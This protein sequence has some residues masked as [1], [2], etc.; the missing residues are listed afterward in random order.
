MAKLEGLA[1][2][3]YE[4]QKPQKAAKIAEFVPPHFATNSPTGLKTAK[5]AKKSR[6]RFYRTL[7]ASKSTFSASTAIFEASTSVFFCW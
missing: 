1:W 4:V 3:C 7:G 5:T 2:P 6:F